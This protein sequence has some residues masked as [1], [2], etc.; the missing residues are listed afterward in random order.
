MNL[1]RRI[2]LSLSVLSMAALMGCNWSSALPPLKIPI[3]LVFCDVTNS[4][5]PEEDKEVSLYAGAVIDHLPPRSE[6]AL[7][8]IQIEAQ[9]APLIAQGKVPILVSDKDRQDY[10]LTN[11]EREREIKDKI[12]ALY[13]TV[14]RNSADNRT[15]IL[16]ALAFANNHL[17]QYDPSKYTFEI[18]F[19]SDMIEECNNTPLP[20]RRV[21]LNKHDIQT[22][23][24]QSKSFPTGLDL[25]SS[26]ITIILPTA[27]V[28]VD[29]SQRRRPDVEQ[30]KQ[31]WINILNRCGFEEHSFFD[32]TQ[33]LSWSIGLPVRFQGER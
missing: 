29:V 33:H 23:V 7:Y 3:V 19:I 13:K 28:T 22:E 24:E 18:I 4:L 20:A 11:A 2:A 12:D 16:N 27:R 30:L 21:K 17:K 32:N 1:F 25:G 26:R 5:M 14:N 10:E 9:R 15:C 31:F 8:P 6:F